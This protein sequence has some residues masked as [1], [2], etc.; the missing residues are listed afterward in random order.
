[1]SGNFTNVREMAGISVKSQENVS[2]KTLSG[3]VVETN[4]D[5]LVHHAF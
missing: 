2:E 5:K 3:K 4:F 1:M